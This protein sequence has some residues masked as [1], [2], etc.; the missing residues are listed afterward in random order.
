[1][2][3][4]KEPG[5]TSV[6]GQR[7]FNEGVIMN[8]TVVST[9]RGRLRLITCVAGVGLLFAFGAPPA[10]WAASPS[11]D[12]PG[13]A[14]A[15][16]IGD[17][18]T[19]DTTEAT[20]SVADAELNADCGAPET[21]A[22]VWYTFTSVADTGVIF[23]MTESTYSGG[24]LVFE[25]TPSA[26]SVISCGPG[27]VGIGARADTT[28]YVMVIDD[29]GDGNP[30]NGGTLELNAIAAPPPPT[31]DVNL[32]STA[33]VDRK[34]VAHITGSYVCT[35]AD[36]IEIDGELRQSV[37]RFVVTGSGFVYEEGTCDGV[38]H[39]FAMD[40]Q[41]GNGKFAGGKAASIVFSFACNAFDCASGFDE[42]TVRLIKGR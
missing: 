38:A 10:A 24:F 21:K 14:V 36:F 15:I 42:Q 5:P 23:D 41:G 35:D 11:N 37:G 30:A 39:N 27:T 3:W 12:E 6:A 1:M 9:S 2:E 26:S 4:R 29:D 28:Y 31:V 40:I 8:R 22:S 25:G 19:L 16:S 18:I 17:H 33:K 7:S 32:D 20:T 13:G 34:G